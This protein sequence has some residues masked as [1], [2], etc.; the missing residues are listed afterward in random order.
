[1]AD[2]TR[3]LPAHCRI[4][5]LLMFAEGGWGQCPTPPM[6]AQ[7][8]FSREMFMFWATETVKDGD[9]YFC[10]IEQ[11]PFSS[12]LF[13]QEVGFAG[14][15]RRKWPC[16]PWEYCDFELLNCQ[17]KVL[18][19]GT[20]ETMDSVERPGE[21]VT[22]YR[23][24]HEDGSYIG[25]S[26]ALPSR[27]IRLGGISEKQDEV[28]IVRDTGDNIV[29]KVQKDPSQFWITHWQGTIE[30]RGVTGFADVRSVPMADPLFV[31]FL[32]S[33]QFRNTGLFSPLTTCI[34]LLVLSAAVYYMVRKRQ[35]SAYGYEADGELLDLAELLPGSSPL[36]QPGC[37]AGNRPR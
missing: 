16:M 4:C 32:V 6:P 35:L 12:S 33:M 11:R 8:D 20:A 30:S 27:F 28:M 26:S 7:F 24:M 10:K 5:L 31:S 22:A 29:L 15:G 37:C 23:F 3:G 19:K 1:M 13:I 18:Y 17:G 9:E 2:G 21:R 34:L 25:R 36:A 14:S